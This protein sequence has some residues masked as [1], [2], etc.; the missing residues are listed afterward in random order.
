MTTAPNTKE[1]HSYDAVKSGAS[2]RDK[3]AVAFLND[4]KVLVALA[5]SG[6]EFA[7]GAKIWIMQP[8]VQSLDTEHSYKTTKPGI[9]AALRRL[10]RKGVLQSDLRETPKKKQKTPHYRIIPTLDTL[11]KI[12]KL[13][14]PGVLATVASTAFGRS[15]IDQELTSYLNKKMRLEKDI[16]MIADSQ[17]LFALRV[18][19]GNSGHALIGFLN[20]TDRNKERKWSDVEAKGFVKKLKDVAFLAFLEDLL[21]NPKRRLIGM[22]WEVSAVLKGTVKIEMMTLEIESIYKE[23]GSA[24]DI[25]EGA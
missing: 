18:L 1:E 23:R 6:N 7:Y 13:N 20:R 12:Y 2:S 21:S 5:E 22:N 15:V 11:D 19:L 24:N 8:N 17:D 16:T 10:E 9:L 25:R 14:G 3:R 4:V